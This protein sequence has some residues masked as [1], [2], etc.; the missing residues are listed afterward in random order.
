[1]FHLHLCYLALFL[2]FCFCA[3]TLFPFQVL[4]SG[5]YALGCPGPSQWSVG[6][7]GGISQ[8][9]AELGRVGPH[10]SIC[11][12]KVSR[13]MLIYK[14]GHR[15]LYRYRQKLWTLLRSVVSS[16]LTSGRVLQ[17]R[18]KNMASLAYKIVR[19]VHSSI[20]R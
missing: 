12:L 14:E 8:L 2:A 11:C 9:G 7:P 5:L 4:V 16:M 15:I 18:M 6:L 3:L 19:Y 17:Y 1:M 20:H 10:G 13:A